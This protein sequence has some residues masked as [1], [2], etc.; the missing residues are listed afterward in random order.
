MSVV[1]LKSCVK[2]F[3]DSIGGAMPPR[4]ARLNLEQQYEARMRWFLKIAREKQNKRRRSLS[5]GCGRLPTVAARGA[6][7]IA[8]V[9]PATFYNRQMEW[10]KRKDWNAEAERIQKLRDKEKK[11]S[12]ETIQFSTC[13]PVKRKSK[14]FAEPADVTNILRSLNR[15]KQI[16][17]LH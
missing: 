1:T 13:K 4:D 9:C 11:E 6:K 5:R 14:N 16:L 17:E 12:Q 2:A 3:G 10:Q 15:V 8:E 7:Q